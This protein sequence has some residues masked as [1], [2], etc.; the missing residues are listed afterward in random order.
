MTVFEQQLSKVQ[1]QPGFIAALD[2]SG[3]STPN[4]LEAYSIDTSAYE[5]E[6]QMFDMV[7][8]MRSRI[9]TSPAFDGTKILGAIL[10]KNTLDRTIENLPSSHYLWQQ[11]NIVPFLKVD[12]GLAEKA[13]GVQLLKPI[14]RL[15]DLLTKAKDREVFGTK[16]RS[17]IWEPNENG[18]QAIVAQ[19][20]DVAKQ[21]I[22]GGLVP[23]IEPEVNID[24]PQKAEAEA[25]LIREIMVHLNQLKDEQQIMLKL[26]LP[27]KANLYNEV[28]EHPNVV[29]VVALSG[30]YPLGFACDKLAENHKVVASFSRVLTDGLSAK[31]TDK[32]FNTTLMKTVERIYQASLT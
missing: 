17:V 29:R 14:P 23:I 16:M 18:I 1:S 13:D 10:F 26:T 28:I 19:Q 9:I 31:Q 11:K 30:G 20:F 24:S 3:G 8:T 2:Q 12:K 32:A 7:H 27:E 25:I 6:Q 22:A 21:I 4:A 5:N 15:L